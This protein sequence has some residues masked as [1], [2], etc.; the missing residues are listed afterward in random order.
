MGRTSRMYCIGGWV[1][2]NI[3]MGVAMKRKIY[4]LARN[5]PWSSTL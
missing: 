3:D 5:S 4:A 2:P 1:G